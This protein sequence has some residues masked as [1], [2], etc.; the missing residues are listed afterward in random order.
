MRLLTLDILIEF[1]KKYICFALLL[2]VSSLGWAQNTL[3]K[4]SF[5][6]LGNFL[7]NH[8]NTDTL[9]FDYLKAYE[10]KAQKND[11]LEKIFYAK[12]KYIVHGANFNERLRHAQELLKLSIKK[13]DVKY[14][15][16]AYNKLALVYYK[17]RDMEQ[18]LHYELLA[19]KQLAKTNDLYNLNKSRYGIGSIYYFVG[20]YEKALSFFTQTANYYK[21]QNSYNDLRGYI[22]SIQ[23][24]AKCYQ[25]LKFSESEKIFDTLNSINKKLKEHHFEIENAYLSLLKG[26]NL[27]IQKQYKASLEQVQKALPVIKGNDDFANEHLAYLYIGKNLWQLN[28]KEAAVEQFKKVDFLYDEKEYSDLNL[29]EAYDYLIAYYKTTNNLKTQLFYT[30]KLLTVSNHLQK[31]YKGLSNVLHTKYETTKL[32]ASRDHLQKELK[33]Q[34]YRKYVILGIAAVVIVFLVSCLFYYK[35]KQKALRQKYEL[36]TQQRLFSELSTTHI[37]IPEIKQLEKENNQKELAV[38]NNNNSNKTSKTSLSDKKTQELLQ[39]L[40]VFEDNQAYLNSKITINSL[41]KDL[42]TNSKYLSEVIN[43][44][45]GQNFTNYLN[46]LRIKLILTQFDDNKKLRKLTISAIAE[47]F[48]FNNAR[49]FSEAFFK[50]TG[51]KPSYY[52]S[53]LE[54]DDKAA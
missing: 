54:K 34:M 53:Q 15:G 50:V 36:F 43:N 17:E 14:M 39:K 21:N 45:K 13:Q 7:D 8:K 16:L 25:F 27:Y 41:A 38:Y 4:Q 20:N 10:N 49:S 30:E 48:G 1:V 26:Q 40:N 37:V 22:N 19:E 24:K 23:Y 47:E 2:F 12:S 9:Y 44:C 11:D 35:K 42:N 28:E 29:L 33:I 32:E 31:Q 51:L 52:I 5:E 6:A 18:S 3:E 46:Q